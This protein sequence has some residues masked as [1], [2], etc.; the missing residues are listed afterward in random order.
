MAKS[1]PKCIITFTFA[2]Y[3]LV[4]GRQRPAPSP[5]PNTASSQ[6]AESSSGCSGADPSAQ[7]LDTQGPQTMPPIP[8]P[9]TS[10]SQE[11]ESSSGSAGADPSSET[12]DTQRAQTM[13]STEVQKITSS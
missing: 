12:L 10:S 8:L 3:C 6:A 5:V 11:A 2:D 13:P 4:T 9:K 1:K 7:P